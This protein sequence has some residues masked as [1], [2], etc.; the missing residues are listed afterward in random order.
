MD[1]VHAAE[2]ALRLIRSRPLGHWPEELHT[3][4]DLA[5]LLA[6]AGIHRSPEDDLDDVRALRTALVTPLLS[7]SDADAAEALNTL[8][9]RYGLRPWLDPDSGGAGHRG[10]DNRMSTRLAALVVPALIQARASGL[11]HRVGV[12]ADDACDTAFLDSSRNA[13]R[14]Y[15]S[16]RCAT[17]ARVA[18]HRRRTQQ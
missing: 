9:A 2:L 1:T 18:Q 16:S 5:P 13:R 11:L 8:V 7:H 15:C 4:A 14:R 10:A 6:Q 17:R 12:C 3:W